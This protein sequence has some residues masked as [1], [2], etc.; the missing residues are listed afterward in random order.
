M[1]YGPILIKVAYSVNSKA[2]KIYVTSRLLSFLELDTSGLPR[3]LDS[4][5]FVIEKFKKIICSDG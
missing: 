5:Q 2:G 1:C 4:S 3:L